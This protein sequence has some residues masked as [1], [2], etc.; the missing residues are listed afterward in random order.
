MRYLAIILACII[1]A[2]CAPVNKYIWGYE[3]AILVK[4]IE[5][6]QLY[7]SI[8]GVEDKVWWELPTVQERARLLARMVGYSGRDI[9]CSPDG[10]WLYIG[11]E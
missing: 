7:Y 8:E 2:S 5:P 3:K 9:A 10:K 11:V 6:V 4:N 1:L